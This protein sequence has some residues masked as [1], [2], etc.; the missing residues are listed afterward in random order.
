LRGGYTTIAQTGAPVLAPNQATGGLTKLG[1]G[2]L[3]LGGTNT[4]G[5]ATTINAGTLKLGN[6]GALPTGTDVV[7]A[8]GT[9]D[10]NGFAVTNTLTVIS[11]VVSNGALST[12]ISPA[13]EGVI[14]EEAI[15]LKSSTIQGQYVADV[16]PEGGCDHVTVV[17]AID[18][19]GLT[20]KIVDPELLDRRQVYTV[21]TATQRTGKLTALNLPNSRWHLSYGT[22]GS[23]KLIY[24]DGAVLYV[25]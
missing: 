6:A 23:V 19:A 20:F 16:S 13:G 15:T 22:D 21:L 5:G 12:V 8:G 9:L 7:L 3:T 4:Y 1:S 10:L 11:G 17:G 24:V 2:T 18:L 25:R 14:G